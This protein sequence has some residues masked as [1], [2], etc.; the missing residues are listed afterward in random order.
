MPTAQNNQYT[1]A[2]HSGEA[3]FA[4][5]PPHE[6][7]RQVFLVWIQQPYEVVHVPDT[8]HV[9]I[10]KSSE[11]WHFVLLF[12]D[13]KN[14]VIISCYHILKSCSRGE[15]KWAAEISYPPDLSAIRKQ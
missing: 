6:M 9:L 8:L 11:T 1:R 10:R 5:L 4:P 14:I 7:C 15:A 12:H 3:Y 13:H 2:A